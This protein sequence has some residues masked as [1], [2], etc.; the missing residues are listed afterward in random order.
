MKY[1]FFLF[2][3]FVAI[4]F[5]GCGEVNGELSTNGT[6]SPSGINKSVVIT[7][8][9]AYN[10]EPGFVLVASFEGETLKETYAGGAEITNGRIITNILEYN[11]GAFGDPWTGSGEYLLTLGIGTPTKKFLYTNGMDI[12][13][14]AWIVM[15]TY[16]FIDPVSTV[17]FSKFK[18]F[19]SSICEGMDL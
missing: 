14:Y 17:D 4:L 10:G 11:N 12:N 9:S 16:N 5:A 1:I 7:G 15:Y 19:D 2:T 13:C 3:L 8:L 6:G 18:E